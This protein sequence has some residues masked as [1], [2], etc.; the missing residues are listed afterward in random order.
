VR[1]WSYVVAALD[2]LHAGVSQQVLSLLQSPQPPPIQN[3]L[4]MLLNALAGLPADVVLVLDDYHL[5]T[6]QPIH[7][8][9]LFLLDHLPARLHLVVS[10]R[11]DPPLPLARWRARGQLAEVRAGDL[12]FTET[13]AAAFLGEVMGLDLAAADVAALAARTEGWAAGLQLAGL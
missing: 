2:S 11:S 12:R 6:A 3:V 5:I 1:F 13:E 10:T 4:T 8:G 9:L 7:E